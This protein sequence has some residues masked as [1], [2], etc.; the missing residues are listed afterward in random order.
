MQA[1]LNSTQKSREER[2]ENALP[3]TEEAESPQI[4]RIN[5]DF[6]DSFYTEKGER[7]RM[8]QMN[9]NKCSFL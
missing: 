9:T 3:Y 7:P 1:L 5:A 8:T 2:K 6:D 4:T